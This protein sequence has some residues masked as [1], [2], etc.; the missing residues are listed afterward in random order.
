MQTL[1][2]QTRL[3]RLGYAVDAAVNGVD[4]FAGANCD[5]LGASFRQSD[6][7]HF[8]ASGADAV[9]TRWKTAIDAV[10]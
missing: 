9:A 2:L 10:Y 3:K 8:N 5:T 4:V 7:L 6:N 1:E